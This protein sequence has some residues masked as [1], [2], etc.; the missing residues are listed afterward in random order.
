MTQKDQ[1]QEKNDVSSLFQAS[2]AWQCKSRAREFSF[3]EFPT[4]PSIFLEF[5]LFFI[6]ILVM[7][8]AY[9]DVNDL[10]QWSLPS[11][12]VKKVGEDT[13][14]R[15][16]SRPSQRGSEDK[17]KDTIEIWKY[18]YRHEYDQASTTKKISTERMENK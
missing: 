7:Y 18:I 5:Y 4:H 6:I 13:Q 16:T 10:A 15:Q 2:Q 17:Q 12:Q 3:D 11:K 14:P 9:D 8:D 1:S